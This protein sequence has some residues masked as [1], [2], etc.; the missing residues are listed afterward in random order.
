MLN[1]AFISIFFLSNCFLSCSDI[2]LETNLEDG[3]TSYRKVR[4]IN[5]S[6]IEGYTVNK[7]AFFK[8]DSINYEFVLKLNNEVE[9]DTVA[10]YSLGMV[11]F[12]DKKYL[13]EEQDYLIWGMQPTIKQ[14]GDY[15]YI[16][17]EVETPI[18]YMDSL[19]IFLY[20]RDGYKGVRGS[21]IRLKNIQL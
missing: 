17:R 6:F 7:I 12:T 9:E 21:L 10:N 15:K 5:E 8:K 3:L 19:H 4:N 2:S 14:Y 1:K 13:A 20:A 16:I 11:V 18:K